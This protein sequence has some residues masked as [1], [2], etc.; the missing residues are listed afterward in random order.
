MKTNKEL[1]TSHIREFPFEN[2]TVSKSQNRKRVAYEETLHTIQRFVK[3]GSAI[4][5]FGSGPCDKTVLIQKKGYRCSACDDLS[6]EW[7]LKDDN[8]ERIQEYA[9]SNGVSFHLMKDFDL[10]YDKCSFDMIMLHNVLEHIVDSPKPIIEKLI[11]LLKDG[12]LLYVV[13]PNLAN[14]RKRISL[15]VGRTNLAP[16]DLYYHYPGQWRGP[17]REYV[18]GDL[19][20][21]AKYAGTEILLLKTVHHMLFRLPRALQ[22]PYRI[23]CSIIPDSKDTWSMIAKK[24]D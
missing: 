3:P 12:G 15:L 16:F 2:Y 21:L 22:L 6:D 5:D 19:E 20:K 8:R 1:V 9:E 23:L 17:K 10:P 11:S 18:R 24:K 13:I 4:L 14:L 7:H